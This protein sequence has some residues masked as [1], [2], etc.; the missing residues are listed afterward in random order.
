MAKKQDVNRQDPFVQRPPRRVSLGRI[1]TKTLK[2]AFKV[3]LT[4]GVYFLGTPEAKAR[5]KQKGLYLLPVSGVAKALLRMMKLQKEAQK[6]QT[7]AAKQ[8]F[9]QKIAKESGEIAKFKGRTYQKQAQMT[10]NVSRNVELPGHGLATRVKLE[11]T[12][13]HGKAIKVKPPIPAHR[14]KATGAMARKA[15]SHLAGQPAAIATAARAGLGLGL[16]AGIAGGMGG[17]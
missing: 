15:Q 17:R 10:R 14:R 3:V 5:L 7:R 2:T 8:Y 11:A 12:I 13:Q 9:K 4:A 1:I 16:A 6:A